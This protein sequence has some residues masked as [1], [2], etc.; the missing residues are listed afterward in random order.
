MVKV[1]DGSPQ[2]FAGPAQPRPCWLEGFHCTATFSMQR[3]RHVE[4]S[5]RE[6]T[7]QTDHREDIVNTTTKGTRSDRGGM[8]KSHAK[9]RYFEDYLYWLVGDLDKAPKTG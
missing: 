8:S 5:L 9:L 4:R 1:I 2:C 6:G 7:Q 3:P